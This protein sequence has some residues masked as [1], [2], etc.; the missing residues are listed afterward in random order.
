MVRAVARLLQCKTFIPYGRLIFQSRRAQTQVHHKTQ[1]AP[2]R[3]EWTTLY[4]CADIG[5]VKRCSA[6]AF[7]VAQIF[8]GNRR[9]GREGN[10]AEAG[11]QAQLLELGK[12]KSSRKN[13]DR[14]RSTGY[15][16]TRV[17]RRIRT[18][19][20]RESR[21]RTEHVQII[22]DDRTLLLHSRA[23]VE[24]HA[25]RNPQPSSGHQHTGKFVKRGG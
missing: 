25:L 13:I 12:R 3:N 14:T 22:P 4:G 9:H 23:V 18:V 16:L 19:G 17:H 6:R 7:P 1:Y 8:A 10:G 15:G 21:T 5:Q 20:I 24:E 2:M 11:C